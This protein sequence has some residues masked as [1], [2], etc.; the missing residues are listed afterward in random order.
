[1][2][3]D[4]QIMLKNK[5]NYALKYALKIA[6]YAPTYANKIELNPGFS[7]QGSNVGQLGQCFQSCC[8]SRG[9]I[10]EDKVFLQ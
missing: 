4:L 2:I 3:R 8:S 6:D 9:S 10:L 1:M 5:A 7:Y